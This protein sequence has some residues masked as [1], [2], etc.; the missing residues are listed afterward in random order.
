MASLSDA[1]MDQGM[2]F[3][4]KSNRSARSGKSAMTGVTGAQTALTQAM[5][6]SKSVMSVGNKSGITQNSL[7]GYRSTDEYMKAQE[8]ATNNLM[9][10]GSKL[11]D[12]IKFDSALGRE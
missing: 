12:Y 5:N 8:R 6:Q 4:S 11:S 3:E 1:M 9:K 2:E 7:K 10:K